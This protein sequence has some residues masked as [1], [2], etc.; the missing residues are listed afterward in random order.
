MLGISNRIPGLSYQPQNIRKIPVKPIDDITTHYY[1]RFSAL[2]RPG[3]LARVAGLLGDHGIS[4]QTVHQRG[5]DSKGAV[6]IVMVTH[7]AKEADVMN[8]MDQISSLDVIA[9]TPVLIR[10]KSDDMD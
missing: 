3:V 1:F 2:D 6:P 4:I 7:I 10:I 9:D 8:A 5:R